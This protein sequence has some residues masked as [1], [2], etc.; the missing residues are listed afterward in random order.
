VNPKV[1]C[2]FLIIKPYVVVTSCVKQKQVKES[3]QS[4]YC[5]NKHDIWFVQSFRRHEMNW[6]KEDQ[7]CYILRYSVKIVLSTLRTSLFFLSRVHFVTWGHIFATS[8]VR[9]RTRLVMKRRKKTEKS[10]AIPKK[11]LYFLNKQVWTQKCAVQKA[12]VDVIISY[13]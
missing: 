9:C 5:R 11:N 13:Y 1:R 2:Q 8:I 4:I 6:Y 12:S 7:R 3:E 10:C